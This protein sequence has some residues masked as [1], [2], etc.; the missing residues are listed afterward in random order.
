[1]NTTRTLFT[2]LRSI[3]LSAAIAALAL[4][5]AQAQSAGSPSLP[6]ALQA[7]VMSGNPQAVQQ[8][9]NTLSGGNPTRAAA[10][11]EQTIQA[12]ERM[13]ATNPNGA[14]QVASAAV[15]TVR[16][17][18]VQSTAPAATAAVLTTAARIFIAPPA[19]QVAPAAVLQL[20]TATLDAA[21]AL[22]NP[23]LTAN[24]AAQSVSLAE[25]ALATNPAAA[26]GL[27]AAAVTAMQ[28]PP[29]QNAAPQQALQV[30]T[31]AARIAAAPEA[32]RAA[33]QA[34]T[35]LSQI[36]TPTPATRAPSQPVTTPTTPVT[37][38][39]PAINVSPSS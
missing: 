22:N 39:D 18:A 8:A 9:I 6:P 27:A 12:A 4:P 15:A 25:R 13:L 36:L 38:I 30:T 11:A 34:A 29:V 7:A 31:T 10:L 32:Q 28:N 16:S 20:A 17:T 5:S 2:L 35:Q 33:P 21:R 3:W 24:L 1:M 19:Y 23:M 26:V 37:P 14:V